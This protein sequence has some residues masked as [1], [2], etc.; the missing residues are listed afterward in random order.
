[1]DVA[2]LIVSKHRAG[3]NGTIR[4]VWAPRYTKFRSIA[5]GI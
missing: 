2:E 4:L 3:P 1:V 5:K